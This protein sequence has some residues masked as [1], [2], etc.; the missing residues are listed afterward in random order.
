M[1]AISLMKDILVAKNAFLAMKIS[2]INEIANICQRNGVDANDV[3]Y[4]IGLDPRINPRFL[5]FGVG[6]G[7]SCFPKD[8]KAIIAASEKSGYNPKLLKTAED[9]NKKQP[10]ETLK[11]VDE[12]DGK[13]VSILGLAFKPNTDDIREAPSIKLI[14]EL[15]KHDVKIKAYDPQA[16]ENAKRVLANVTYC[17]DPYQVAADADALILVTEWNE[18]KQLDMARIEASM[19]S[20][21][22]M[23]GRNIYEPYRMKELG[24][25]YRGVGRGYNEVGL[26]S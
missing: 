7:G 12:L 6:Y 1:F 22:L 18:F 2:F 15:K 26:E 10:L 20:P 17:Q 3:A 24:F 16:V 8:V 11:M 13:T 21:V 4:A 9:V 5:K 25:T 23:D 19:R 14:R